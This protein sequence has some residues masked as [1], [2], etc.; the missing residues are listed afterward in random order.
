VKK[1]KPWNQSIRYE[2]YNSPP[3][4]PT[5]TQKLRIEQGVKLLAVRG[6]M[7]SSTALLRHAAAVIL[8]VLFCFFPSSLVTTCLRFIHSCTSIIHLR[9]PGAREHKININPARRSISRNPPSI[10]PVVQV[11][12]PLWQRRRHPRKAHLL[13][14]RR[15]R[16][17][18]QSGRRR[19]RQSS[20]S[21]SSATACVRGQTSLC[22]APG[23]LPPQI[24]PPTPPPSRQCFTQHVSLS[25]Y[26]TLRHSPHARGASSAPQKAQLRRSLM[27]STASAWPCLAARL[28]YLRAKRML[29]SQ[30]TP[31]RNISPSLY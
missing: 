28:M 26:L 29:T 25:Q 14:H 22:R 13:R 27:R 5:H 7:A 18:C 6:V 3:R 1:T 31:L 8:S 19:S 23:A 10:S 2:L 11:Y 15:R 20:S 16:R 21:L 24:P 17:R 4:G 30:K 9:Y 12:Y